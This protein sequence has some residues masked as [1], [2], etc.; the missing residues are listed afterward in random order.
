VFV[1]E[2]HASTVMAR[3]RGW[4]LRGQRVIGSVPHGHYKVQTMLAGIRL[5]GPVA[6][7]VFDGAVNGDI[8]C[9][10]VEQ[11][12]IPELHPGD[13]VVADNLSSH[14]N[15]KAAALIQAAGCRVLF[16]PPY[17]PDFNPIEEM[18]SKVKAVLRDLEARTLPML[19]EAIK[20]ALSQVTTTDCSGFFRHAGYWNT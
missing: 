4:G 8:Y 5:S 12:L 18:W 2:S 3:L 9:A 13:V 19:Y 7:L 20:M 14:K 17:S 10:W 6:P 11:F 16:L 15:A 1:D